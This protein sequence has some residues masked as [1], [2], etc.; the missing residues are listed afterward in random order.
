MGRTVRAAVFVGPDRPLELRTFP[1]PSPG[2]GEVLVDI[3]ACTL[4]GSDVHS[5][6]GRRQVPTPTIL[7]H[8]ILGRIADFG[9]EAPRTDAL[10]QPLHLGDRVTWAIVA[11]CGQ[12]FYCLRNLPQKCLRG[13]KYGHQVLSGDDIW[14]G[15]L[16]DVCLLVAGT[17]IFRIPER[18]PNAVACPANCA[19]ATI[20]AALEAAGDVARQN[21][22]V[23]G[24]G[25]LG[26]TACA[27]ASAQR[28]DHVLCCDL[29]ATRREHAQRFGASTVCPPEELAREVR[30]LTAGHGVD[31]VLELTGAT[32]AIESSLEQL[33]IGGT[34]VEVGAVFPVP[35]LTL[36]PEKLVRHQW[37]LRGIHNYA[38]RHLAQGV[39]FLAENFQQFPFEQL[40]NRWYRLDEAPAALQHA[41]T[42]ECWRVGVT[43]R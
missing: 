41:A 2:R 31:V 12:C 25:M 32:S 11:S 7:G 30:R 35:A 16:A 13:R 33:R 17:A 9:P 43:P 3:V 14:H 18:L 23:M 1:L 27:M 15:G 21:V 38:P 24:A 28:A 8:E 20:A 40:V 36:L 42:G 34:L 5:Y 37:T 29:Q 10:G 4:C 22:L 19:T 6:G 39:A 26:L